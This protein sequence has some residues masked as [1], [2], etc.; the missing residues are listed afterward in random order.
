M[1]YI[2][3]ALNVLVY[4][5]CTGLL[6]RTISACNI[7]ETYSEL[8]GEAITRH[9]LW[10]YYSSHFRNICAVNTPHDQYSESSIGVSVRGGGGDA[11]QCMW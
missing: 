11:D 4:S 1:S 3:I 10:L 7:C 2:R 8:W 5:S 9:A 6:H